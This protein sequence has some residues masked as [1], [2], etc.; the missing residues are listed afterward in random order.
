MTKTCSPTENGQRATDNSASGLTL[1]PISRNFGCADP[2]SGYLL[3]EFTMRVLIT[4]GAGFIAYHLAAALLRNKAEVI[5]LDN[6]NDFYDPEIKRRNVRD[7]QIAADVP[8]HAVDILDRENL[9]RVFSEVRPEVIVHLA[10]WA[11]VRP[12]L[13]KPWLYSAVN[14]TG[15]VNMLELAREF[16]TRSFIFGSSSSVYGGNTKVP[17][18]ESDPVDRPVSPYAAT[19]KAG[20]LICHTYAHNFSMH[21]TC[22][23]FFTVY[24]PRQRPEMAIH[25]FAQLMYD[26][27]EIPIFGSGESRRDYTYVDDIVAGILASI[28][29]NPPFEIINLGESQTITLLEMVRQLEDALGKKALLRFLPNQPGDMEITCADIDRAKRILGYNPQKPFKE[30]IRLFAEW[31][32]NTRQ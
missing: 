30:G 16:A 2:D 3:L 31:F 5:L 32:K 29:V 23:R 24:G 20:E 21:I 12:S 18:S 13:E 1:R 4:G 8:I 7:L 9:R 22:L 28:E 6:F 17:F 15:T 19:K 11:G 27:K 25:K 10:A 14:V 26:G